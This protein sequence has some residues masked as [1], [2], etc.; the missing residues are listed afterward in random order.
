MKS[1]YILIIATMFLML[2]ACKSNNKSQEGQLNSQTVNNPMSASGQEQGEL[3]VMEIEQPKA[4]LGVVIEGEKVKHVFKF[5]NT[6]KSDLIINKV[7]ASCGCT[8]P[9]WDK[10]PIAP[11]GEGEIEVIFNS[12]GRSGLQRKTISVNANTQPNLHKLEFFADIVNE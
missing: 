12:S 6:G 3:P 4:D 9:K 7:T 10:E 1:H 11:G 2:E 5:K 8:V